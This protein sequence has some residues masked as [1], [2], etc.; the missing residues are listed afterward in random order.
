[1]LVKGLVEKVR[2]KLRLK[3]IDRLTTMVVLAG[4]GHT[5]ADLIT[6]CE[7]F[8]FLISQY[9]DLHAWTAKHTNADDSVTTCSSNNFK[10]IWTI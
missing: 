6:V 10:S 8:F 7:E 4:T 9:T 5:Q 2:L 1:M 3:S